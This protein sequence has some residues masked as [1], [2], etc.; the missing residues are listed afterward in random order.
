VA[1]RLEWLFQILFVGWLV[2]LLLLS[3]NLF[4]QT[5][6]TPELPPKP[7]AP[8]IQ[9]PSLPKKPQIKKPKLEKPTLSADKMGLKPEYLR[10]AK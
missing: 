2:L 10:Y 5:K 4:A 8:K 7:A 6:P 1:Y 3:G 9:K